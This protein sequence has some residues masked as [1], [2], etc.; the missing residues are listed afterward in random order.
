LA[1]STTTSN[2]PAD[3]GHRGR[4]HPSEHG[5]HRQRRQHGHAR[6]RRRGRRDPRRRRPAILADCIQRFPHGLPTGRAG[7]TTAGALLARY[8]IHVV[9]P[10]YRAGQRDPDLLASYYRDAMTLAGD[11]G[12]AT[13]AFP[14]VSAGIYGWP[15][16]DAARIAG[17]TVGSFAGATPVQEARFVLFGAAT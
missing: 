5:R 15:L 14:A 11:L 12:L 16:D 17:R 4:H 3:D 2:D 1:A 9:G 7:S 8:V 13:I 10:N 6:R